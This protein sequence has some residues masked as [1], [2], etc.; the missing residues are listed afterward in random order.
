MAR[1]ATRELIT[2]FTDAFYQNPQNRRVIVTSESQ[3]K[4]RDNEIEIFALVRLG[5]GKLCATAKLLK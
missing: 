2:M 1:Y 4:T 5:M 3:K